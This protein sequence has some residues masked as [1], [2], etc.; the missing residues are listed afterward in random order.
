MSP[1][2]FL[3]FCLVGA[4][5]I[6]VNLLVF[7]GVQSALGPA[8]ANE[9]L[10]F[11][12]A[13]IAGILVSILTN[14]LLNDVWTWGGS[15]PKVHGPLR[16]LVSFYGVSAVGAILQLGVAWGVREFADSGDTVAVLAGIAVATL[17]NFLGNDRVTFARGGPDPGRG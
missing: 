10:R 6:A 7:R 15:T 17:V 14:F 11:E 13:H 9:T 8:V 3:R 12:L 4:S 2:R 5:G 16:R 1:T